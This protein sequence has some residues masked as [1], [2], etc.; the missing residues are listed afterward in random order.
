MNCVYYKQRAAHSISMFFSIYWD[1]C[2]KPHSFQLPSHA[3]PSLSSLSFLLLLKWKGIRGTRSQRWASENPASCGWSQTP[4]NKHGYPPPFPK[5]VRSGFWRKSTIRKTCSMWK[6]ISIGKLH[7]REI[8]M[9]VLLQLAKQ[10]LDFPPSRKGDHYFV[11]IIGEI[12][13]SVNRW[14]VHIQTVL[15]MRMIHQTVLH[16]RAMEEHRKVTAQTAATTWILLVVHAL[17]LAGCCLTLTVVEI[18]GL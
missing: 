14:N 12:L 13:P 1:E 2:A 17:Y 18:S 11:K 6:S 15:H 5:S 3:G 10:S 7:H 8:W 16:M 4:M 9:N